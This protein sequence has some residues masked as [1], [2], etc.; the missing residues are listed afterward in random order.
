MPVALYSA[1]KK[2][3]FTVIVE[4]LQTNTVSTDM[5]HVSS[6]FLSVRTNIVGHKRQSD[7][8]RYLHVEFKK[9]VL[10]SCYSETQIQ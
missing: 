10:F 7:T 2:N 5:I 6:L 4:M 8:Q 3:Y 9:G 1:T